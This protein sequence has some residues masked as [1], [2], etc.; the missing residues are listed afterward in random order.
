M[1]DVHRRAEQWRGRDRL[2]VKTKTQRRRAISG[3]HGNQIRAAICELC[4]RIGDMQLHHRDY[5]RPNVTMWL[6]VHCH[7][8]QQAAD[9]AAGYDCYTTDY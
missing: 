2:G 1:I 4:G 8:T 7:P 6:C 5:R 9:R 3:R